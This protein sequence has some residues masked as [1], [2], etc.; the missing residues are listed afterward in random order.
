[1]GKKNKNRFAGTARNV[2][3]NGRVAKLR[4]EIENLEK[5]LTP[6]MIEKVS[7]KVLSTHSNNLLSQ[8]NETAENYLSKTVLVNPNEPEDTMQY[9]VSV[10]S[11][12]AVGRV[13]LVDKPYVYGYTSELS[14]SSQFRMVFPFNSINSHF[15]HTG[16]IRCM[17][18][19]Q[20]ITQEDILPFVRTFWFKNPF[21]DQWSF[22]INVYKKYQERYQYKLI[23]EL[24]DYVFEYPEWHPLSGTFT[25]DNAINL[26]DNL[27]KVDEVVVSTENLKNLLISLG[28]QTPITVFQNL[29]PK[30]YYG[31][32]ISRRYRLKNIDKPT[33]LYNGSNYHYGK[34]NGDFEGEIKTFILNNL[35]NYNFIFMGVGRRG[36]G[37]LSLPDYLQTPA[38]E[39]RIKIM[40]HYSATEYPYALRQLRPDY[41]IAP[42]RNCRFNA[43][44]SDLRYLEAAAV[45]AVFIGQSFEDG[46]SPYQFNRNTFSSAKDISSIIESLKD[47]DAFNTELKI[48]YD[49]LNT[50]WLDDV[51]NL[52]NLV[53]IMGHGI[54]GV[55]LTP[56]HE[57]YEQLKSRI[58]SDG[59]F[60]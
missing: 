59:F 12:E 40:P 53:K 13:L 29:L 11:A 38:K 41:V 47:K 60:R 7:A 48:Q 46:S 30:S 21:E 22:A 34:S 4:R 5:A 15:S 14:G 45:G 24:D 31:T 32:D 9:N 49:Q 56:E 10:P 54:N 39:G 55:K 25:I 36:D 57:Q 8:V 2:A 20:A 37:S 27:S 50:R 3:N 28:V 43:A 16:K 17:V 23:A 51:N 26:L 1:M 33:I 42:L 35:D 58:D 18:Q 19:S 6:E 52:L 44:K